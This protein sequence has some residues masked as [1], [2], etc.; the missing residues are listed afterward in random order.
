MQ[1]HL[2]AARDAYFENPMRTALSLVWFRL[3]ALG[4][5]APGGGQSVPRDDSDGLSVV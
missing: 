2:A 5:R 1:A 4:G 3:Q